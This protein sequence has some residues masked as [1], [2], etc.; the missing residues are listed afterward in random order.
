MLSDKGKRYAEAL[1]NAGASVEYHV[2]G[3]M[4]HGFFGMAPAVDGA[5]QAQGAVC[6]AFREAF[7]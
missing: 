2:Y 6:A 1:R 5:V 3:G 7:G 4:I